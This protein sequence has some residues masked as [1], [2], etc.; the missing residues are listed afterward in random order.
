MPWQRAW[1]LLAGSVLALGCVPAIASRRMREAL[2][3]VG[4]AAV[5][6][7]VFSYD[8]TTRF[9]GEAALLPVVGT[10]LLIHTGSGA[11][12]WVGRALSA[13]GPVFIGLLSYSLYLWH[14]P[15][16]VFARYRL[17]RELTSGEGL[18]LSALALF[19]AYA[20]WRFVERPFRH[21][22]GG[23][24]KRVLARGVLCSGVAAL[25]GAV[26]YF[27]Q[28]IP[29]R[30]PAPIR[31]VAMAAFDENPDSNACHNRKAAQV[32]ADDVCMI[33]S[34]GKPSF[35]VLGDSFADALV[36]GIAAAAKEAG[37]SGFV[38]T[39][40]GCAPLLETGGA[41]CQALS[42]ATLAFLARH[43]SIDR[44]VMAARW[45]GFA[46]GSRFGENRPRVALTDALSVT[47]S[48]EDSRRV[49]AD[50]FDRTLTALAPRRVVVIGFVPEQP[51]RP[52]RAIAL[53]RH[54][55]L[56][57]VIGVDR[58]T[59]DQRQRHAHAII[60]PLA[61][62]PNVSVIDLGTAMCDSDHCPGERDGVV[63]YSD[64]NHVSRSGA[65]TL[66]GSLAV[67]FAP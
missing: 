40:G 39:K 20:S 32:D 54:H 17:M 63:L 15:I 64:D 56:D 27:S 16:F 29:G 13:R 58:A 6:L 59:Y 22:V 50:G 4:A 8:E 49:L 55:G 48:P 36:P 21:G 46:E 57:D 7:A 41:E 9:P 52:S 3:V 53:A 31:S 38:I 10:A 24:Q 47:P 2:A 25:L 51:L 14:W 1:E 44:V 18:L 26:L 37:R 5:L 65:L 23:S 62:R 11:P 42:A 19:A 66:K 30:F 67:A 33:G 43:P 35:V 61:R 28:G 45:S 34:G 12:T 60:D